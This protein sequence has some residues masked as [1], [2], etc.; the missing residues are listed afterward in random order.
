MMFDW[1]TN[2]GPQR[3]S[4]TQLWL[5]LAS[6]TLMGCKSASVS[7][8]ISPRVSGRVLAADTRQPIANVKVKRVSP[9]VDQNYDDPAKGGRKME[10]AGGVRTDQQGRFMLDAERDLTLFQQQVWFSVMVSFQHDGYLTLRTNFTA[11]HATTNAPDGAPVVNAG[12]I[13]LCPV[14]H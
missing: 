2:V 14:S 4:G 11:V 12:E 3:L 13:L 10:S 9:T 5:L 6:I 7:S 8:Y 1:K